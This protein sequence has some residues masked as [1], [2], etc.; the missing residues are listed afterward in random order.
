MWQKSDNPLLNVSPLNNQ[1]SL[2]AKAF[3]SRPERFHKNGS[4]IAMRFEPA[5][6][7]IASARFSE[8]AFLRVF[9]M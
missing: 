6:Q 7:I 5:P 4:Q 8:R 2:M 3:T 9:L 1:S